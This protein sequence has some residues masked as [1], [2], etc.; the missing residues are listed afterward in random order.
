MESAPS[1]AAASGAERSVVHWSGIYWQRKMGGKG[2][3]ALIPLHRTHSAEK[4]SGHWT[5]HSSTHLPLL[6]G[7]QGEDETEISACW[8]AHLRVWPRCLTATSPWHRVAPASVP[9][10][11][12]R[13]GGDQCTLR[14]GHYVVD[15]VQQPGGCICSACTTPSAAKR[16]SIYRNEKD[17][18]KE[19]Q[20]PSHYLTLPLQ[21]GGMRLSL[22]AASLAS[23]LGG[24]TRK[25][26][27]T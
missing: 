24:V 13:D 23:H 4:T 20:R 19:A 16:Q 22:T 15:E 26:T 11:R 27:D 10:E 12:G 8:S 17:E 5:P 21:G 9:G 1:A 14:P 3:P 7:G 25:C 2:I 6:N 18:M